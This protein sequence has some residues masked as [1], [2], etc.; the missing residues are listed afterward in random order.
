MTNV[1]FWV[2]ATYHWGIA[3]GGNRWESNDFPSNFAYDTWHQ[4][5]ART[6]I[7]AASCM[8]HLLAGSTADGV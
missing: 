3:G 5:W 2:A 8:E 7:V 6:T 1:P 4:I